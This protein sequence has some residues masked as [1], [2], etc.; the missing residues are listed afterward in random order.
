MTSGKEL[1]L[2][3]SV[4]GILFFVGLFCYAFFP[5]KPPDEPVRIY[6]PSATGSVLFQHAQHHAGYDVSCYDCHHHPIDDEAALIA[7]SEC[8]LKNPEEGAPPPDVCLDCHDIDEIED[9]EMP[10]QPD[11]SHDQ[12]SQ[13]HEGIGAGPVKQAC[14]ECHIQ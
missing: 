9:T 13:C 7:C 8:H 10:S 11:A 2:V 5:S 12:C 4:A 1:K 6:Y 3:L 14:S